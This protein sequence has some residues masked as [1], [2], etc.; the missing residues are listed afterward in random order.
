MVKKNCMLTEIFQTMCIYTYKAAFLPPSSSFLFPSPKLWMFVC[1]YIPPPQ[2]CLFIVREQIYELNYHIKISQLKFS[3]FK[4]LSK[5][6]FSKN[7]SKNQFLFFFK[8][9]NGFS[10]S[11]KKISQ[12]I[13]KKSR[14][15]NWTHIGKEI[16]QKNLK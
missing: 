14:S 4:N 9:C 8:S 5:N 13:P 16:S 7:L 11:S 2:L 15:P 10:K 3:I 1:S 12:K 6:I